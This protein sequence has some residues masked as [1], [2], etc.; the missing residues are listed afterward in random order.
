MRPSGIYV[1]CILINLFPATQAFSQTRNCDTVITCA[2]I[3]V[4]A[5]KQA[6]AAVA[7]LSRQNA[8]LRER[9]ERTRIVCRWVIAQ[10]SRATC[11][12]D[13]VATGCSQGHNRGSY[14]ISGNTCDAS[15]SAQSH[16][17]TAAS[18]CKLVR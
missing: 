8:A 7:E 9:L 2:Q 15:I 1:A 6:E 16:D 4:E 13:E 17:W 11:A 3:A 10:G 18:C 12:P 5:A 14:A